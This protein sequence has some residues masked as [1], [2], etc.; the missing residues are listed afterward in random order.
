MKRTVI[1]LLAALCSSIHAQ[2]QATASKLSPSELVTGNNAFAAALYQKI[3]ASEDAKD[4]NVFFSPYSVSTAL[5]MTYAGSRGNTAQQM[6]TV[7]R[8]NLPQV[9]LDAS[10]SALLAQTKT[11]E[12]DNYQLHVANALWGEKSCQFESSF[13]DR[14]SANYADGLHLVDFANA[15]E[16]SRQAMN[17]WVSDKT[18]G[19][20]K[21]LV[22]AQD[23]TPFSRLVLTNA[24]YFKGNWASKF[25]PA[26]TRSGP[27]TVAP[28]QVVSVP[29]MAQNGHF[30]ILLSDD[31]L[32]MIEL[33]Y[34]GNDLSMFVLLPR[35]PNDQLRAGLSSTMLQE[36]RNKMFSEEVTVFLPKFKFEA[37]YYLEKDLSAMG[38]PDA[39]DDKKA[40]FSGMTGTKSLSISHVIHQAVIEVNEQGSEA[41][42]STAA[43]MEVATAAPGR[44]PIV[45][46]ADHPFLFLIVHRPTNSILFIGQVSNPASGI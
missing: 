31:K 38:M 15:T 11:S 17:N 43:E 36:M 9:Q 34:A 23:L 14:I 25:Y 46:R 8:F 13:Q 19:K 1:F 40:D 22:K 10:I 3:V 16:R 2:T 45:F 7:L 27:F 41:T 24:I 30:R 4:K 39:F 28:G 33:P 21:D 29:M 5:A 32:V 26:A 18:E 20:V 6:A 12:A 42:A 37:R 44:E 35:T